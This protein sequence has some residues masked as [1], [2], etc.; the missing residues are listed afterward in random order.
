MIN[1]NSILEVAGLT[2]SFKK[3]LVVD[4][5]SFDIKEGEIWGMV[6]SNG[7]GKTTVIKMIV[8]LVNPDCGSVRISGHDVKS[9][10]AKALS[11][12]G[13]AFE[14]QYYYERLTAI[15]N[16]DLVSS[17]CG[18]ESYLPNEVLDLVGLD[19]KNKTKVSKFST[20]MR[21]RIGLAIAL[22]SK[23]RLIILD[24]PT[25]GLDPSGI[26]DLHLL[27]KQLAKEQGVAFLISSHMLY[28]VERICDGV[29]I[30]KD[31]GSVLNDY[32]KSI[33]DYYGQPLEDIYFKLTGDKREEI[34]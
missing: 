23:P 5:L 14:H 19:A 34:N 30:M 6:G 7:V 28:D 8:G 4:N 3:K 25:N 2:K 15:Q 20:G 31:G 18:K 10:Y 12:V 13:V 11:Q 1:K 17:L 21:Q 27:I 26:R 32:I 29:L 22:I 24:E 9:Q 16:M 33:Q